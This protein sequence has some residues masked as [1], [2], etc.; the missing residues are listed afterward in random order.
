MIAL[1]LFHL[2]QSD[3][4]SFKVILISKDGL[5]VTTTIHNMMKFAFIFYSKS[6]WYGDECTQY[7]FRNELAP[8]APCSVPIPGPCCFYFSFVYM[9]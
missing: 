7:L 8:F 4:K 6:S 5:T 2:R 9:L 1:Y 3:E